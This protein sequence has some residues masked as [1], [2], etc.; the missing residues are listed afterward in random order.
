MRPTI[1]SQGFVRARAPLR[2]GLAGG[3]T[4]LV[5]FSDARRLCD[6]RDGFTIRL[7]PSVPPR[8]DGKVVFEAAEQKLRY[9]RR[10]SGGSLG[11]EALFAAASTTG[12]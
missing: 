11:P 3:G 2:L 4:D 6:E 12:S 9:G 10:R 7:C 8:A 5:P 1:S